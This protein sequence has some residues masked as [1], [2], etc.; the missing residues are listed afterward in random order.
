V[1]LLSDSIMHFGVRY[2]SENIIW[3]ILSA[4]SFFKF[5][6]GGISGKKVIALYP[7]FLSVD[8]QFALY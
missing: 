8:M 4:L 7:H 6:G 5:I 3:V 2:P 1:L